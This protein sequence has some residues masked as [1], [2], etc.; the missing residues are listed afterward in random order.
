[1]RYN[2]ESQRRQYGLA[3]H[4]QELGFHDI[5]VIDED[6]GRSGSGCV[7]RPGFQRLVAQVKE[8]L[9]MMERGET[10]KV[11]VDPGR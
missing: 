8:A 6:L 1:M 9:A 10:M 11:L 4:A 3:A 5:E 7:E 2:L